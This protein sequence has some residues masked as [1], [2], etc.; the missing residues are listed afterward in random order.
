MGTRNVSSISAQLRNTLS[1]SNHFGIGRGPFLRVYA[2]SK[3]NAYLMGA[4]EMDKSEYLMTV[5]EADR[6]MSH[7]E[8]YTE[9]TV[10]LAKRILNEQASLEKDNQNE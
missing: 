7:P 10:S 4:E 2:C 9:F 3:Q 5:E 8:C 1:G 6:I